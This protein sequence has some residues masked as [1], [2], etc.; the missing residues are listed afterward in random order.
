MIR[1]T[2]RIRNMSKHGLYEPCPL[3]RVAGGNCIFA[4][5]YY[6]TVRCL[7]GGERVVTVR[8]AKSGAVVKQPNMECPRA[9][10][11]KAIMRR[12]REMMELQEAMRGLAEMEGD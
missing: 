12:K 10:M 3:S 8:D 11:I 5:E 2:L 1:I 6:G 4:S 9:R 7:Y